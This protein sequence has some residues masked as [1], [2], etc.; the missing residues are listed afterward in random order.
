VI[1]NNIHKYS[2]SALCKV[3]QIPRCTY[4]YEATS[5]TNE[6]DLSVAVRDIFLASRNN[7]GTRKIK[8]ELRKEGLQ[9][10]RR[11]IARI[12]RQESLVS[13]YTTAQFKPNVGKC[14]ESKV[15]NL[16]N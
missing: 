2:V 13:N 11:R 1:R 15:A 4:Y 16:V 12:M 10:S 7:Y 14:N 3:L 8:V 6:S 5:K 9:V